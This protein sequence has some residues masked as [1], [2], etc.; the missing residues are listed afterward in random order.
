MTFAR[1]SGTGAYL[2]T[3]ILTNQELET[4]VET[5]DE[6]IRSR[7]G[8]EERRISEDH[9][10]TED[11]A[12]FA[13]QDLLNRHKIHFDSIDMILVAT[14]TPSSFFPNTAGY[15]AHKLGI[16][17]NIPTFDVCTACAGFLFIM[18]I[19]EKYILSGQYKRI[20]LIGVEKMSSVLDWTDRATCILFGDGAA[21]AMLEASD[22][23][24]LLASKIHC[25]Y[26]EADI[27]S[28][29]NYSSRDERT[30]LTMQGA[31]VFKKAVACMSGIVDSLLQQAKLSMDDIDWFVPH[32]AN[33]RIVQAL[34]KRL[35]FPEERVVVTL[36]KHGNTSAA[37]VP[38]ALHEALQDGRIKPGHK[39]LLDAFGGGSAW[40]GAIVTF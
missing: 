11:L 36:N 38:L 19:A 9:E 33:M 18:D 29:H 14:M 25:E 15:V 5:S 8:I 3:P 31:E 2:P 32:Q 35:H 40:A 17:A 30:Y 22:K 4:M 7:T 16:R 6:W 24:G 27:L 28:L 13:A 26:D 1:I 12:F 20:L 21:A 37:S 10:K 23:P 34:C 39:V